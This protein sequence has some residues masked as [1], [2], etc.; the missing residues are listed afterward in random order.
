MYRPPFAVLFLIIVWFA[1]SRFPTW[2]V[3]LVVLTYIGL[4]FLDHREKRKAVESIVEYETTGWEADPKDANCETRGNF[5]RI[6]LASK[7]QI[8]VTRVGEILRR[9]PR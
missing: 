5:S 2:A 3:V 4:D 6:K 8:I 7:D 1:S 9:M